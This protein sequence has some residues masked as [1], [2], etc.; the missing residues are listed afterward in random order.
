M[1]L[2][3]QTGEIYWMTGV[4]AVGVVYALFAL[5]WGKDAPEDK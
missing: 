1:G 4:I 3:Y 2:I 5:V